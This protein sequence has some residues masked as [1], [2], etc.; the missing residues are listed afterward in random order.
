MLKL[1]TAAKLIEQCQ[2]SDK[3]PNWN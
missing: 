1:G 2:I 3:L